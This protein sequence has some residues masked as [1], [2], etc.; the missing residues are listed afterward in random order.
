MW[1]DRVEYQMGD[2]I[3]LNLFVVNVNLQLSKQ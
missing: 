1:I 2:I 3:L